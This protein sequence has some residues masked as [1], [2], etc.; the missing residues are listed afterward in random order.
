MIQQVAQFIDS[1][2]VSVRSFEIKIGA[3]NGLIRRAINNQT[4]I[5]S[6]WMTVIVENYPQIN[7]EWLLTGKGRMLRSTEN[8]HEVKDVVSPDP[9]VGVKLVSDY[10][11]FIK[12]NKQ[13]T[14]I[15][16]VIPNLPDTD[17]LICVKDAAMYPRYAPGDV[18]GFK[19]LPAGSFW[20][21]NHV[22]II[23]TDQG[24]L[25]RRVQQ[26]TAEDCVTL[27]GENPEHQPFQVST[28]SI[29]SVSIITALIRVE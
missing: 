20:Q 5:L 21:W 7:P 16:Y 15:L 27:V 28:K 13:D 25:I 8:K 24:M 14:G 3:S 6:K 1:L 4:D 18:L 2:G 19:L 29:S 12:G 22:Y 17:G 10:Q 9:Q 26:S 11:Q 23:G